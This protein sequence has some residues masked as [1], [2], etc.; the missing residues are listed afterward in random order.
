LPTVSTATGDRGSNFPRN[1]PDGSRGMLDAGPGLELGSDLD[2]RAEI[3]I[4]LL[5]CACG[6]A[7]PL[8]AW[9]AAQSGPS[10]RAESP[11][12]GGAGLPR[13][14]PCSEA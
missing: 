7:G 2:F 4:F 13:S 14:Q 11:K 10:M 3:G 9:V 5:G 6:K 12:A 8:P 1:S